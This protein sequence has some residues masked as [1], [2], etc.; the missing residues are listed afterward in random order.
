MGSLKDDF[1]EIRRV[2]ISQYGRS[3]VASAT[4]T[5]DDPFGR[6]VRV[7]LAG[8]IPAEKLDRLI[9]A[10][11]DAGLLDERSLAEADPAEL[12]QAA[13]DRVKIRPQILATLRR[14]AGWV[15]ERGGV[16]EVEG[17]STEWLRQELRALKGLGPATVE[18]LLLHGFDRPAYPL[19][20]PTY[21]V[22]VRHGWLDTSAGFDEARETV[23]D[24]APGDP[25]TLADLAHF[26]DRIGAQFCKPATARCERCP[27]RPWLPD[28]GPY[29]PEGEE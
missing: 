15:V 17:R 11:R 27:L 20:R 19:D 6:L 2:L 10:L 8:S 22:F 3:G 13:S 1:S 28:A 9:D 23:E 21:R 14:L 26:M 25:A 5:P 29:L 18:A 7:F 24:L 12:E 16:E 4:A